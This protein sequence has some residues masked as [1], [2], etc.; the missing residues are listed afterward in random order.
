MTKIIT[1]IRPSSGQDS[2]EHAWQIL[3]GG[4]KDPNYT[5]LVCKKEGCSASKLVKK[6]K[7]EENKGNKPLL[8]G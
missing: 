1:E 2:H 4:S 8:F 7:I 6:P 3:E 5:M